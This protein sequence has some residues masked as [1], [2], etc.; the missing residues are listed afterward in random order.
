M[1]DLVRLLDRAA[2]VVLARPAPS[3]RSGAHADRA[4]RG[5]L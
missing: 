3:Q 2:H 5:R 4:V 1:F